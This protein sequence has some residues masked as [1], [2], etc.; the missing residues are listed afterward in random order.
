MTVKEL[1]KKLEQVDPDL[2]VV[3][4]DDNIGNWYAPDAVFI[5]PDHDGNQYAEIGAASAN[6]FP[7]HYCLDI[8]IKEI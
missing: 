7:D 1:I 3:I 8:P 2:I 5:T 4:Y 6:L